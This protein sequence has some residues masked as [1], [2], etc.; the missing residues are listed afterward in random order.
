MELFRITGNTSEHLFD[1][2]GKNIVR[3][4]MLSDMKECWHGM[5]EM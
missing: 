4:R 5:K 3:F 1:N 2:F